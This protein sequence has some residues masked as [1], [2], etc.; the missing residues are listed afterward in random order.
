MHPADHSPVPDAGSL[1]P[2]RVV[3]DVGA[4]R[5]NTAVLLE[6]ARRNGAEVMAVV[7]ADAYGHGLL[8]AT[9]AVLAGGATV[10]GVA[11]VAEAMQLREAGVTAPLL[12]WLFSPRADL[13]PA[14]AAGVD[15]SVSSTTALR[16]VA[17]A[18]VATG[19][20]ASVHL[21]VD[22]GLARGGA[23]ADCWDDLVAA[24]ARARAEG[25]VD[26]AGVWSHL[27]WADAPDHPTVRGQGD[28]FAAAVATAEAA[29]LRPRWRH[30]ANSAATLTNASAHWDLVRPGIALYGLSP[31]PDI[32]GPADLGLRA[33]M[34][35]ETELVLVKDVGAGQGVSYAH[36]YT[37]PS[38]TRLGLVP[39]GYADGVPRHAGGRGPVQVGGRR[40]TVAGRV[41]MDQLVVDLGPGAVD[42]AGDVAV[43]FGDAA[44][45]VPTAQDWAV[46]AGTIGY[47]IVT[48]IGSRLPRTYVGAVPSGAVPSGGG[49]PGGAPS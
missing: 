46:A 30:L 12:A 16:Q 49:H 36:A 15:L 17:A 37:T 11:Q 40:L 21:K 10:L 42:A 4:I 20:T 3:V 6:R 7:K 25:V 5:D 23:T 31:V 9:R 27:A 18:A 32:A 35:V 41:C 19:R 38:A 39:L 14:V 2:A 13:A 43:L 33:A 1:H 47:E 24:A 8:P 45:G 22:T 34:T 48:R 29:G 28:A 44:A 26:V